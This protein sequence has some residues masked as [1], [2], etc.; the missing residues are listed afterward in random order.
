M[1]FRACATK[2]RDRWLSS[3]YLKK[4]A[5][6]SEKDLQDY[7]RHEGIDLRAVDGAGKVVPVLAV[8]D[9]TV[10]WASDKRRSDG[11]PSDYGWHVIIDHGNNYLTWYCH[12]SVLYT[13]A[14]RI[15]MQGDELGLS[16]STGNSTGVHLHFN[17]QDL[18]NG[19]DGY[20]VSK[21]IDP[22][23]MLGL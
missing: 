8:A 17:I 11:K 7:G 20:V 6:S 2:S 3:R 23:P 18:I 9:G 22:A 10:V 19:L 4:P 14:G 16:G 13:V 21:V 12:L 1:G 15:V 5:S